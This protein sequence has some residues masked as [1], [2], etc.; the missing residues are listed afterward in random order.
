MRRA[1]WGDMSQSLPFVLAG[2]R[3]QS[4]VG[5]SQ[6]LALGGGNSISMPVLTDSM[7][8]RILE[9]NR[10]FLRDVPLCS[11]VAFLNNVGGLWKSP[12]SARRRLY[13]RNLVQ[14]LGY[15]ERMAE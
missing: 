2:N 7:V 15:S 4:N 13:I 9:Q 8:D 5:P 11:I 6:V 12:E 3:I 10:L 1:L 14:F